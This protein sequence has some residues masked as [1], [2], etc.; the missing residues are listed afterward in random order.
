MAHLP[1]G[2][3]VWDAHT[4]TGDRDPDG[5]TNTAES[6]L[7]ALDGAGHDAAVICPSA[8]PA[9]YPHNNDRV[10]EEAGGSGGRLIPFLRVDPKAGDPAAEVERCLDLGHRGIKLHPR[11]ERFPLSHQGMD[12]VAAVAADRGVP[13]L[14][15]AGRGIPSLG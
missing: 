1:A 3:P 15:H 9:G 12:A 13:L 7:A 2:S 4:H 6:L 5:K 8:D 11:S 14:I 10:L